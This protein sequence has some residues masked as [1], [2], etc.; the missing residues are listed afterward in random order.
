MIYSKYKYQKT[1]NQLQELKIE[2][3]N[4]KSYSGE[5]ELLCVVNKKELRQYLRPTLLQLWKLRQYLHS[6]RK[7]LKVWIKANH[8]DE[9]TKRSRVR[10]L[11][12]LFND[13]YSTYKYTHRFEM[14]CFLNNKL[15]DLAED[16]KCKHTN[17]SPSYEC[18]RC[19]DCGSILTDGGNSWGVAKNKWFSNVSEAKFYKNNGYLPKE[20]K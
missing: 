13:F 15:F 7:Y 12:S 18:V 1:I 20:K 10:L 8:P 4:V 3:F 9:E 19:N 17:T 6:E 16:N 14:I 2:L 5:H 11:N